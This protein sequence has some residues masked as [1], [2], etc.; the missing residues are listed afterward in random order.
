[1]HQSSLIYPNSLHTILTRLNTQNIQTII[2]G[3]FVR[4]FFLGT[5]SK[6]IDIELY[7]VESL[8]KVEKFLEEFGSV[9][10]VGSS[11]GVCKLKHNDL[12]IDFS[13]PRTERKLSAGHKGFSV[14]THSNISFKA[15]ALRRDFTIN[16]IGYN[17]LTKEF[18]DPYNGIKDVQNSLLRFVK[19]STFI[20]DPLRILRA[21]QFSARFHLTLDTKLF[22]VCKKMIEQGALYELSQ[23]RVFEELLKLFFKASTPSL[24]FKLLQRLNAQKYFSEFQN[25]SYR[26]FHKS[27][28]AVDRVKKYQIQN[29]NRNTII[30]LSALCYYLP[31]QETVSFLSKITKQ[32]EILRDVIELKKHTIHGSVNNYQLYRLALYVKLDE[33]LRLQ[34]AL[35]PKQKNLYLQIREQAKKLGVLEKS[36]KPII[37]GRDLIAQGLQPSLKFRDILEMAYEN[38]MRE[39]FTTH[40]EAMLWLQE[41]L[42]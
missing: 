32:K 33:L 24:G 4:D 14:T 38:Q 23:E 20:E 6:D 30:M 8:S 13:L 18:L 28:R 17:T 29:N 21:V 41:L 39:V 16:A 31:E 34:S 10:I 7:G 1:M 12:E 3:G 2:V 27:M 26:E 11:F 40:K 5:P 19:E 25:L 9:N 35:F 42:S 37:Q 15:A 22:V 36:L